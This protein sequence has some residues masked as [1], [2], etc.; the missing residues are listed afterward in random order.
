MATLPF[1][2]DTVSHTCSW[3]PKNLDC[4][5]RLIL[6]QPHK[7]QPLIAFERNA[8][9]VHRRASNDSRVHF[10]VTCAPPPSV[11]V[12]RSCASES[13]NHPRL[14]RCHT[15][16]GSERSQS[17]HLQFGHI[18]PNIGVAVHSQGSTASFPHWL[19]SKIPC[20]PAHIASSNLVWNSAISHNKRGDFSSMSLRKRNRAP[21]MAPC[22]TD[23]TDTVV[24]Y[25]RPEADRVR[26]LAFLFISAL[27]QKQII[28][29]TE[30]SEWKELVSGDL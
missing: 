20:L 2:A 27:Q 1:R 14:D 28:T 22:L 16:D 18:C 5:D 24:S 9:N 30:A 13:L 25:P 23:T 21:I 29:E 3:S 17:A 4:R 12:F 6:P 11:A 26:A 7:C 10:R 8:R 15:W 19:Q